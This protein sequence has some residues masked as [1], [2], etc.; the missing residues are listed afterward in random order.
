MKA[1]HIGVLV[2]VHLVIAAVIVGRPRTPRE[3]SAPLAANEAVA[4][5]PWRD[6]IRVGTA[7]QWRGWAG[8]VGRV[9]RVERRASEMVLRLRLN[10]GQQLVR[11]RGDAIAVREAGGDAPVLVLVAAPTYEKARSGSDTLYVEGRV[12]IDARPASVEGLLASLHRR[13][14]TPDT[15]RRR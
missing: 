9:E 11:R 3:E 8:H 10:E 5:I 15:S 6:D 12:G 2:L 4:V 1:R 14:A 7:V 13:P